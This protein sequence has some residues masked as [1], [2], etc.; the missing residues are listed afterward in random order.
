MIFIYLGP[1]FDWND[2]CGPNGVKNLWLVTFCICLAHLNLVVTEYIITADSGSDCNCYGG[3][4]A[5][6]NHWIGSFSFAFLYQN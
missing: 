5:F 3:L 1:P 4:I 6:V 2:C